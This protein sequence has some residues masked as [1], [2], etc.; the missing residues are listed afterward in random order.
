M[1]NSISKEFKFFSLLRFA[2]PTMVM[3]VFMSLYTIV[4][5]IFISRLVGTDAL[6][7]TNIVYPAISLLIAIGVMLATGGSAIIAKKLGEKKEKEAC[8]DFS[9]LVLAAV[10]IGIIF[11]VFGNLFINPIVRLLGATDVLM[12]YC[13]GYLSVCL[14]LAPA[15]I[16]QLVFQTFF[17]TAGK[18]VLGLALT[19]SG[20]IANMILDYVF[21]GVF[22]MGVEGAALATGIGQLI[23]ALAGII[24]FLFVRH[25]LYL[26]KPKIRWSVLAESSFNGSSEMV[27]NLSGAIVTFLYNIMMLKLVG[28]AGVAA[29]TIVLYGQ[30]LFNAL[31]MGFSM[32]VAPV[33]SYNYGS[34]NQR[35]LKR[36]FKICV[37]FIAISSI[38]VTVFALVMSPVIVEIF[39]PAGTETYALAKTGFFLF[40]LNFVFAG[41]NIFSSS[42]FTAF[43]DG[44][45]SAIISFVRTFALIVINILVL[46]MLIGVNGVWL[47]VPLA[48][49][50][51]VF[52]SGYFF[53][54][55][56]GKYNYM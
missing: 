41:I 26:V 25:S 47:S 44:K 8:E 35:L 2:F 15:C 9:F 4:D 54:R 23:P 55:K 21:M 24:Y 27:T 38:I 52:L 17:V 33:I 50:M 56:K 37:G 32:G 12:D 31:Y 19:I 46:P 43:S 40:S 48:E 29:I 20:G 42:M 51:S 6:S 10:V 39:T 1:S 53:I 49:F 5:G 14:F 30:F 13:V 28:E 11:M 22:H 3:M 45:T 36:I 7:A 16:L 34:G 18:P